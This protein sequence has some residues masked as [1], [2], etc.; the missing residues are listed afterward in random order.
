MPDSPDR[1][2]PR[3]APAAEPAPLPTRE[4]HAL[5]RIAELVSGTPE[6][7]SGDEGAVLDDIR[8]IVAETN[9]TVP[10]LP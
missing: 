7:L 5:D 2:T 10:V 4:Q 9:R 8:R 3:P 6:S 1:P